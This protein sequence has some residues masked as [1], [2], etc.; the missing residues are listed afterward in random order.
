M[1]TLRILLLLVVFGSIVYTVNFVGTRAYN[2]F[3]RITA[4]KPAPKVAEQVSWRSTEGW[5]LDD[6]ASNLEE[7]G[8][9][10]KQDFLAAIAEEEKTY[11]YFGEIPKRKSL[12]GY[13]FPDT[14]FLAKPTTSKQIIQKMLDNTEIKMTDQMLADIAKQKRTIY[15]VLTLASIVEKE[16]GRN[17]KTLTDQDPQMLQQEREIVAGIF[18]NR[19]S[20]GMPLQSDATI[21]YITK[22]K[23]PSATY[24]E[25]ELDSPY[26]TYKYA[27]LPPG[28]IASPSLGSIKAAIYLKDT[29]YLY[30]LSKPDGTA[31]YAKTLDEQNANKAKYLR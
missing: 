21:G 10:T 27:G 19:L 4:P 9:V 3:K 6:I 8:I 28:P 17:T 12:E 7:K 25:L 26:N 30:F 20:I 29:D 23:S 18:M 31:V 2:K 24:Q 22:S 11:T 16:V 13:L 5:T 15:D 1:K 14:Y